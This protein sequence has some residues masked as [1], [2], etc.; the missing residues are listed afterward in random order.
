MTDGPD[1]N[2]PRF[3]APVP[4]PMAQPAMP[5]RAARSEA[6][7]IEQSRAVA[8]VQGQFV[9]AWQRPRDVERA[10]AAI[11]AMCRIP[12]F[13]EKAFFAYSR[14]GE[15]ISDV[16]IH[17]ARGLAQEWGN[18][19]FGIMELHRD[20]ASS[21]MKAF[22]MN[23]ESNTTSSNTFIQTHVRDTKSGKK[24]LREERDIYENNA[25]FASRRLRQCILNTIP[26]YIIDEAKDL[27]RRALVSFDG[28]K[29][30]EVLDIMC[31]RFDGVGV[32]IAQLEARIGRPRTGWLP[33]DLADLGI[34]FRSIHAGDTTV[35]EEFPAVA[36]EQTTGGRGSN[37]SGSS[38]TKTIAATG[39]G[40]GSNPSADPATAKA[41]RRPPGRPA[42]PAGEEGQQQTRRAQ[43]RPQ[44]A[45]QGDPREDDRGP[46]DEP[47]PHT[48]SEPDATPANQPVE[49][50]GRII[51]PGSTVVEP[52]PPP[53]REQRQPMGATADGP[54]PE[55][56]AVAD[57]P[58]PKTTAAAPRKPAAP[59]RPPPASNTV[60]MVSA[61]GEVWQMTLPA[62]T[63]TLVASFEQEIGACVEQNDLPALEKMQAANAEVM[64]TLSNGYKRT[65]TTIQGAFETALQRLRGGGDG[66][67]NTP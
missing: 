4:I 27:C 53:V 33:D 24:V 14:G 34:L 43:A 12:S 28:K 67:D 47:P 54:A 58:P 17:F 52:E 50:Q 6:T 25:N 49:H 36:I 64:K 38:E 13:A 56:Q 51:P 46:G 11:Q 48:G 3:A 65:F 2:D 29:P 7:T 5:S 55:P 20:E 41:T 40:Q 26:T 30:A 37:D 35:E 18:I 16:S 60:S 31:R 22:C 32:S 10:R 15:K 23:L 45:P 9:A 44:G 66:E 8:Q 61:E 63:G 42:K 39:P 59:G 19:D 57:R 21:E 62:D 1:A